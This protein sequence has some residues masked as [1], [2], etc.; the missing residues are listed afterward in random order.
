M[1]SHPNHLSRP[2][3]HSLLSL[4]ERYSPAILATAIEQQGVFV[5]DRFNRVVKASLEGDDDFSQN[6]A[7]SLLADWQAELNDPGPIY[8]WEH[9]KYEFEPHP[10]Q[11]FGWPEEKLPPL[12]GSVSPV[13]ANVSAIKTKGKN[14]WIV[15]AQQEAQKYLLSQRKNNHDP[16]QDEVAREVERALRAQCFRTSRGDITQAN[17]KRMALA[18]A[19]WRN[20]RLRPGGS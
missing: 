13:I 9:E 6:K 2:P 12:D 19:F 14:A 11:K 7:L 18:G 16:Q 3:W 15:A 1:T 17:I 10:T 8:S 4:L 20:S 5:Y